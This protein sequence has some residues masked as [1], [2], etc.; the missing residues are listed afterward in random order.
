[1]KFASICALGLILSS[2]PAFA[3]D[4]ARQE[5]ADELMR[6]MDVQGQ[7]EKSMEVLKRTLP[8]QARQTQQA[9]GVTNASADTTDLY[10]KTL[11]AIFSGPEWQQIQKEMA[12]IYAEVF[13]EDDLKGIIEF[14]KSPA[15]KAFL[16]KQPEIM[17]KSMQVNQKMMMSIMPR[18][19]E[20]MKET[21]TKAQ[22][23]E[24]ALAP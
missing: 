4:Q 20:I 6:V 24:P 19:Q 17:Q 13:T 12:T 1:M 9:M 11:D 10:Q 14:Y 3:A 21:K 22:A 2:V 7:M 23:P 8:E 15:G 16:D 5:L 18:L